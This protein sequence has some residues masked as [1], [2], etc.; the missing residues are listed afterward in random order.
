MYGDHIVVSP[1]KRWC[2]LVAYWS[3]LASFVIPQGYL[4]DLLQQEWLPL[5]TLHA[6][7]LVVNVAIFLSLW[8]FA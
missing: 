6:A 3:V 5:S 2:I 4:S 7:S 1:F 8:T